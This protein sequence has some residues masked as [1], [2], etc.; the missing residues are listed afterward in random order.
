MS[1]KRFLV[2]FNLGG[3][4]TPARIVE[5]GHAIKN[6]IGELSPD[7]EL[8]YTTPDA[9]AFG[10]LIMSSLRAGQIAHRINSP[11]VGLSAL[12]SGDS[13]LV[14]ELG[15]DT[16]DVANS[17]AQGWLLH[18]RSNTNLASKVGSASDAT[19]GQS[20]LA[21]KLAKIKRTPDK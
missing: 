5:A 17:R 18:H 2:C 9:S 14:L 10:F 3:R 13:L 11:A 16:A 21:E 12:R 4:P 6:L 19:S 1:D 8:A 7:N 15:D 20:Q